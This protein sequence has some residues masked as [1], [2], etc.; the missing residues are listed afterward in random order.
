MKN[1]IILILI[2]LLSGCKTTGSYD[3]YE[4]STHKYSTV[5][6]FKNSKSVVFNDSIT[7]ERFIGNS[8]RTPF[9]PSKEDIIQVNK[10]LEK[11]YLSYI[12]K[13][14]TGFD[15]DGL[16]DEDYYRDEDKKTLKEAK[17]IQSQMKY[18]NK[19]F[20]GYKDSLGRK[21]I[22]IKIIKPDEKQIDIEKY[23]VGDMISLK[24]NLSEGKFAFD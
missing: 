21:L 15:F 22:I 11:K 8:L 1:F 5:Y 16:A 2:I 12:K 9:L 24:Y 4:I 20:A 7:K 14:Y 19:Q 17:D 23:W 6:Q 10:K 13:R 18:L 3:V